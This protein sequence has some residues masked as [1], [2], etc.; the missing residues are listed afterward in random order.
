[1]ANIRDRL[2]CGY[3]MISLDLQFIEIFYFAK[4]PDICSC[5]YYERY[6]TKGVLTYWNK[7][8]WL[9]ILKMVV[10]TFYSRINDITG[11]DRVKNK[12]DGNNNRWA[13]SHV[14]E[15]QN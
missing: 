10:R 8:K 11:H 3:V 14:H 5:R 1:M 4:L 12:I 9:K 7:W 6:E 2:F 13:V 15:M